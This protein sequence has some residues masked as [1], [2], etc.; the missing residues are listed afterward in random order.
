[1]KVV[2]ALLKYSAMLMQNQ[3]EAG[4][5]RGVPGCRNWGKKEGRSR[6]HLL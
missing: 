2:R 3:M 4:L 1:M 5:Q 6:Q